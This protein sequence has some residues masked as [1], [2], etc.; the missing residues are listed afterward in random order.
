MSQTRIMLALTKK[1]ACKQNE[2]KVKRL[3][4]GI[5]VALANA[6]EK[7]AC[8]DDA[9]DSLIQN[10]NIDTDIQQF[11]KDVS[12]AMYQKDDADSAITQL[13]RINDYLFEELEMP[14]APEE[15]K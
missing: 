6:E 4:K 2:A 14:D 5:E 15:Q 9:L 10:F 3:R 1:L 7:M 12:R 8:A 11:I 13:R